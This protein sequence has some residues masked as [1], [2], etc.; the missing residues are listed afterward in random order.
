M[1]H[2]TGNGHNVTLE[3]FLEDIKTVVHDGE[4][5]LKVGATQAKQRAIAGAQSTDKAI[6]AYP[7]QTLGILFG[8]GVLAGLLVAGSFTGESEEEE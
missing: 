5:L 8:L 4:Q 1:R 7:Y 6:R 2:K 3:Q